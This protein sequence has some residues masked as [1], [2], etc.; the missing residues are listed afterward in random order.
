M[1][2]ANFILSVST[3]VV[4][5]ASALY[6][7]RRDARVVAVI[8][9][10]IGVDL[11]WF[12]WLAA[13]EFAGAAGLVV[14]LVWRPIGVAAAVGLILYFVAAVVA[15]LRVGDFK[16]LGPASFVLTLS[17]ACLITRWLDAG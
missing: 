17:I 9:E 11:K 4:L 16:G 15:H 2:I 6:K 8:H 3:A 14:G 10:L 5:V 1:S 7:L 13:C 12:P